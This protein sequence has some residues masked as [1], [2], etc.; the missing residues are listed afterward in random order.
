MFCV[1]DVTERE[2]LKKEV[3]KREKQESKRNKILTEI[4]PRKEIN[5]E[6]HKEDLHSFFLNTEELLS[7]VTDICSLKNELIKEEEANTVWRNLHT[8]KG[9]S[10]TF[11]FKGIS[12]LIH[13]KEAALHDIKIKNKS[14]DKK[15]T[16]ELLES[17]FEIKDHV[18]SYSG[19]AKDMFGIDINKTFKWTTTQVIQKS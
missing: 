11:G 2:A 7:E 19:I 4:A 17:V 3:E 14:I 12:S 1:Q 15:D 8:I 18:G 6:E 16:K 13:Q 9:N 10:R 5:L